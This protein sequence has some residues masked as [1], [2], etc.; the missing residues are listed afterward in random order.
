VG[1]WLESRCFFIGD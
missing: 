1:F